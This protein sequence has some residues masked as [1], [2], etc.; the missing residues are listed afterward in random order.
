MLVRDGMTS[1]VITTT[2]ETKLLDV[3]EILAE[4]RIHQLPVVDS[5][6]RLIGIITDRDVRDALAVGG[7]EKRT[8]ASAM[9]ADPESVRPQDTLEDAILLLREKR[10]GALPV[11][12]DQQRVVGLFARF[13]GLRVLTEVLGVDQP[14]SRLDIAIQDSAE[15][16]PKAIAI[17]AQ[18][19]VQV[20]S[21]VLSR[22]K[23]K[24]GRRL[25]LRLKSI[26]TR[27]LERLMIAA[28]LRV[29]GPTGDPNGTDA[30]KGKH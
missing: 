14:G 15:E 2:A 9:T 12:D 18:N 30:A 3:G 1:P 11:V 22:R 19:E 26:D 28:G 29:V 10:F 27:P 17:L 16:L 24:E 6:G 8:V 13:D 20:I 23:D 7:F 4:K 21:A 5:Q 25:Y